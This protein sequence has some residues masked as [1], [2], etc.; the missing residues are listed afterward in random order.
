MSALPENQWSRFQQRYMWFDSIGL[1][2]DFSRTNMPLDYEETMRAMIERAFEEMQE[3]EKGAIANPDENRMVGHY[4]L[5]NPSIAPTLE[6][7][8][9]IE[10][11]IEA[12]RL[13]AH[14]VH[15]GAIRGK[16]GPFKNLLLI[17]IGGSA[18]GPQFV[19]HALRHPKTDKMRIHFMD[20]TDPD[21]FERV[22]ST[23]EGGLDQTLDR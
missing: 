15:S 14:E 9:E 19:S 6:I 13:F 2:L 17:G 10:D 11:T 21:G 20:N 8:R 16:G 12:V 7:R 1:G 23:L 18:L 5:R 4:W 22:L 3:L